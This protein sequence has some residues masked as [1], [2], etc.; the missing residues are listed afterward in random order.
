[1]AKRVVFLADAM[2][3]KL[4][5]WLRL[6]G[7]NTLYADS[8]LSD[9]QVLRKAVRAKAI[10]LTRDKAFHQHASKKI[11]ALLFR[12]TDTR[13]QLLQVLKRYPLNLKTFLSRTRCPECNAPLEK[14]QKSKVKGLVYP[15]V[16]QFNKRFW[17]CLGC[18]KVY[19]QGAHWGKIS[20]ELQA[21]TRASE[22]RSVSRPSSR[23]RKPRSALRRA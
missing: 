21:L 17:K 2:L 10:L 1:M 3:R 5:R 11:P 6:L 20:K 12:T 13:K 22:L 14:V 18:G 16:Y 19:W 4:C 7:A 8:S 15:A 9:E 23:A